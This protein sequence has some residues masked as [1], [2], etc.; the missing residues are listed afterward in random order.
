[1]DKKLRSIKNIAVLGAGVMGSQIAAHFANAGFK[2]FLFDMAKD[3]KDKSLAAQTAINTMLKAKP[4]AFANQQFKDRIVKANYEDNLEY[5]AKC[6]LVM[7]AIAENIKWKH[8]L[9]QKILPHLKSSVIL[10]SNTSAIPLHSLAADLPD[11][12]QARFLGLH[13]FNPPRYMHLLEI[14][15]H[16]KTDGKIVD[17]L[18]GFFVSKLGKGVIRAKDTPGFVGNRVGVF[19]MVLVD[20]HAQR[21]NLS[22]DLVDELTGSLINR[23]KTGTYR[24]LDLVGL[25]VMSMVVDELH[26]TLAD[27]PWRDIFKIPKW[28]QKLIDDGAIGSKVKKG[29]Y[30]K[31]GKDIFVYDTKTGDYRK[32]K[33]K[34]VDKD[35]KDILIKSK[36]ED[37][38]KALAEYDGEQAEFLLSVYSDLF[39]Y[40]SYHLGDI[41]GSAKE[42]DLAIR[43]GYGWDFGPFETWQQFGWQTVTDYLK[44]AHKDDKLLSAAQIPDWVLDDKRSA[45]HDDSGSWDANSQQMVTSFNHLVYKRQLYPPAMVGESAPEHTVIFENEV[46]KFWSLKKDIGILSFKTKMH[47]LS[48]EVINSI[49]QA[50]DVAESRHKALI[51]W[52]EKSPF[53][54][55]AN[56]YE[57]LMGTKY[58][59]VDK[60]TGLVGK[61][62]KKVV[63]TV[64][65]LPKLDDDLPSVKDVIAKLQKVFMRLKHGSVPTIAAVNGLALGGGCEMLLHCNKVVA[66]LESYVGLVEVG[67]GVLPAGGGCKEMT[68]RAAEDAKGDDLLPFLSKYFENI[69]MGKVATSAY[70]MRDMGYLRSD[71]KIVMNENELLFIAHSEAKALANSY[72]AP[73]REP[74]RVGGTGL[75]ANIQ[76]QL[77]N[78]LEGNFISEHDY[79]VALKIANIMTGGEVYANTKVSD[80]HL[81]QLERESFLALLKTKKTQAR[82]EHMLKTNKPLRN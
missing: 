73:W 11:W 14:I 35:L 69:A 75:R 68:L 30:E 2:V 54:A 72:S 78:L 15:A 56:L 43:W 8:D 51:I 47:V 49:E 62:K 40:C 5:I 76:G 46:A 37:K 60:K 74:I 19:A 33:R 1:M 6:D 79:D 24:T 71:D 7:E 20:Y 26:E 63:E 31:R 29:V 23:P 3:D 9:Y 16:D 41:A 80:E 36:P 44:T 65:D 57:I 61:L 48:Y 70:E 38:F 10:A 25:D 81:L 53:C 55:G 27:D 64:S 67:V 22:P 58:G 4:A 77:V 34:Q 52:Q 82:I 17:L 13:F 32:S 39:H 28:I 12:L 18:E 21:L 45:V 66:S 42:L 50:L 59:A